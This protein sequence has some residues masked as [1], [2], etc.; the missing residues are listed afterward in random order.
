[1]NFSASL[2]LPLMTFP[3]SLFSDWIPVGTKRRNA[4]CSFRQGCAFKVK[5]EQQQ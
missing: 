4:I 3:A 2:C 1:M 5:N